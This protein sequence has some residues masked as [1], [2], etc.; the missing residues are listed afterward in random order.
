[1][2]RARNGATVFPV[3]RMQVNA[4]HQNMV[5]PSLALLVVLARKIVPTNTDLPQHAD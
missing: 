2:K 1:M 5:S 4:S 3:V